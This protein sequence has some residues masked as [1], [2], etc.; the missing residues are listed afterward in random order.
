MDMYTIT[1]I[2]ADSWMLAFLFGFFVAAILWVFR[3]G[4]SKEYRNT[5]ES[6]FRHEDRPATDHEE[7]RT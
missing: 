5:A 6:I 7:A 4:S 3:P 2:F 1:R